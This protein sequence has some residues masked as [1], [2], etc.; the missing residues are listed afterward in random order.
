MS[1][2][3][4]LKTIF[5]SLSDDNLLNKCVHGQPQNTIHS[6]QLFGLAVPKMFSLKEEYLKYQSTQLF[7]IT[8]MEVAE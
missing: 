3:C 8:M 2:H 1:I 6:T 5:V 4:L 7:C